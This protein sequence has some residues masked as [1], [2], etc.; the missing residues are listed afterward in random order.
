[1][2]SSCYSSRGN[3]HGRG[4]DGT[5]HLLPAHVGTSGAITRHAMT[6]DMADQQ[7]KSNAR[8]RHIIRSPRAHPE[9]R[10]PPSLP[11]VIDWRT[12]VRPRALQNL[13]RRRAGMKWSPRL[14]WVLLEELHVDHEIM[15]F[16]GN[17]R[18]VPQSRYAHVV[19]IALAI[20]HSWRPDDFQRFIRRLRDRAR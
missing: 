13:A 12:S 7:E 1:M 20:R 18:R 4:M 19:A 10:L 17:P 2:A 3:H 9:R 15:A 16:I 14:L 5:Q 6:T 11:D 8:R